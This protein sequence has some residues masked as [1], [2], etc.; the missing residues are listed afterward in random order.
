M[1]LREDEMGFNLSEVLK[2]LWNGIGIIL[3]SAAVVGLLSVLGTKL[4]TAPRYVSTTKMYVLAQQDTS[5]LTNG[6]L[7]VSTLLTQDYVELIKSR[8]VTENVIAKLGLNLNHEALLG[9]I[10]V[11]AYAET[12]IITIYVNDTDPY[13][14]CKIANTI[15]EVA[16]EHI[17]DVMNMEA[18]NTVETANVPETPV[19]PEIGKSAATG[20]IM[21]AVIA[22]AIILFVFFSNDT[23]KTSE[24]VERYLQLSTLGVIPVDKNEKS[25]KKRGKMKGR[26]KR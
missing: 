20:G 7:Q 26:R 2:E 17:Q 12:R 5:T 4:F 24:D 10:S 3:L 25:M 1:N 15:R 18:V 19:S 16:A 9:K 8:Q 23:V 21:G 22:I 14:A 13:Q 11:S 6:D